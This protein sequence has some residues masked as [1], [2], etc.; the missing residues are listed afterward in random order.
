MMLQNWVP[1]GHDMYVFANPNSLL[2]IFRKA[3]TTCRAIECFPLGRCFHCF[4]TVKLSSRYDF[5]LSLH[6]RISVSTYYSC[7]PTISSN[8]ARHSCDVLAGFRK[9]LARTI[10]LSLAEISFKSRS[11]TR[12]IAAISAVVF[13]IAKFKSDLKWLALSLEPAGIFATNQHFL[14]S[15]CQIA[16]LLQ[17]MPSFDPL[18]STTSDV[19]HMAIIPLSRFGGGGGL[20][21]NA[22]GSNVSLLAAAGEYS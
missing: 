18:R 2:A 7:S 6:G 5:G 13:S 20:W 3:W 21:S 11:S 16:M 8:R 19:V 12:E 1:T 17:V 22:S 9:T 14:R 10:L 4:A 15:V